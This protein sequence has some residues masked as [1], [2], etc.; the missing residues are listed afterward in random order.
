M[1]LKAW[2]A[3]KGLL[4]GKTDAENQAIMLAHAD[5][6][7]AETH[8][9]RTGSCQTSYDAAAHLYR[10]RSKEFQAQTGDQIYYDFPVNGKKL[11]RA[12]HTGVVL[13]C[14][15]DGTIKDAEAN[16]VSGTGGDQSDGQ[17]VFVRVRSREFVYGFAHYS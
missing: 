14:L 4:I 12:H 3:A 8:I 2:C 9:A 1:Y 16:T 17:G 10:T 11:G 13:E 15:P 7:T 6:F 5:A